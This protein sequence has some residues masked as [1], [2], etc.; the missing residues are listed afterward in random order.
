MAYSEAFDLVHRREASGPNAIWQADHSPLDIL[1]VRLGGEPEKPWL[2][3]R[4]FEFDS[5]AFKLITRHK[6]NGSTP[7][8]RPD[9]RFSWHADLP[10][11]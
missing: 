8:R 5:I 1:L 11:H 4:A 3:I 9:H 10:T 6:L 2:K 7:P